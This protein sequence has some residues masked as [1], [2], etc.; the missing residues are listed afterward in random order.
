I[1][2]CWPLITAV[3]HTS[4]QAAMVALLVAGFQITLGRRLTPNWRIAL[5]SLVF[6]RL[7]MP[8]LPASRFSLSNLFSAP[9]TNSPTVATAPDAAPTITFGII[10][11]E[12]AAVPHPSM[13]A[14]TTIS[15]RFDWRIIPIILW[16]FGT[17]FLLLRLGINQ[18][19]LSHRL[20]S[21]R[22]IAEPHLLEMIE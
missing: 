8:T 16:L 14:P 15:H 19:I 2:N 6:M 7:I 1:D 4:L 5:W 18:L 12:P 22:Q 3:L 13:P 9:A 21:C 20:Q 10:S 17:A 11:A